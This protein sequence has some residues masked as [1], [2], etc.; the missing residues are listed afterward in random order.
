MARLS[1]EQMAELR[2]TLA[3]RKA[4]RDKRKPPMMPTDREVRA[5]VVGYAI[6]QLQPGTGYVIVAEAETEEEI[7]AKF[8]ALPKGHRAIMVIKGRMPSRG[9]GVYGWSNLDEGDYG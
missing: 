4:A 9:E 6:R 8:A 1:D 5:N 3:R 7:R 2:A